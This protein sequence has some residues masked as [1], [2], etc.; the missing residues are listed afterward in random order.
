VPCPPPVSRRL[1]IGTTVAISGLVL[2]TLVS[3]YLQGEIGWPRLIIDVLIGAL[4]C[5]LN[6]ILLRRPLPV[7][8][9]MVALAAISPAATPP[10]TLAVLVVAQRR[11]LQDA[12]GV[13]ILGVIAHAIQGLL[14]PP[15]GL[16]YGWWLIL[17]V[18]AHAA[19]VAIGAMMQARTNLLASLVLRAQR[20]EEEQERRIAEARAAERARIAREMHDVLA[21]RLSLVATYAGA[22]EFRADASPEKRAQAAGVIRAGIQQALDELREVITALREDSDDHDGRGPQPTAADLPQLIEECRSAGTDVTLQGSLTELSGLPPMSDRAAYR[23]IQEGL[24]NA[25]RHAPG[26]PVTLTV[27]ASGADT[28]LI[29]I[30][31]QTMGSRSVPSN[32]GAGIIG[33]TERV[34][35]AGGLLENGFDNG[36]FYLRTALPRRPS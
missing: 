31:N 3:E 35:L 36:E 8:M 18:V 10:A 26:Q 20:A 16:S 25:R 23:L 6:P 13:A 7:A 2:I 15:G 33:M 30:R 11:P 12:I 4:A 14:R 21:H 5:V 19:L 27:S 32:G 29:E 17:D 34:R 22:L 1:I 24:T 9:I 28:A